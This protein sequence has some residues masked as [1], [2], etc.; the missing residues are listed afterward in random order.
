ME[1][2]VSTL[3]A[4]GATVVVVG[5]GGRA[6][7]A[8]ARHEFKMMSSRNKGDRPLHFSANHFYDLPDLKKNV[9]DA[10]CHT[11]A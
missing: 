6:N 1:D 5:V 11:G 8:D 3:K 9:A 7:E 10:L 4:T 2:T